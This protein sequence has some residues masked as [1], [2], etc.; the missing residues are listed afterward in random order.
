MRRKCITNSLYKY[1]ILIT[2]FSALAI[3]SNAKLYAGEVIIGEQ[4]ISGGIEFI[5]E[6]A[7]ADTI[8]PSFM[9]LPEN[10]TEA[11]LEVRAVFDK[12]NN[13]ASSEG[14][15]VPYLNVNVFINNRSTGESLQITLTPHVNL[16]D[17]FHYARNVD[18]PGDPISDSYDL[19][20]FIEPAGEFEVQ[21]HSDFLVRLGNSII[22]SQQF[23]FENVNFAG[24]FTD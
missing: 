3:Y 13:Y 24:L 23:T 12:N 22:K 1:V 16:A 6:A 17:G 21:I 5:F 20:Y 7:P 14:G 11:H 18:L 19:K 4:E 9:N 10:E 8:S 15:F 2:V